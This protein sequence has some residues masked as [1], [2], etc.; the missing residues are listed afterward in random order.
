MK[1]EIF[2]EMKKLPG[3]CK[4]HEK[5]LGLFKSYMELN[6]Y[7]QCNTYKSLYFLKK[8]LHISFD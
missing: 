6:Q 3:Y 2:V 5:I 1:Y 7:R 8:H 4:I